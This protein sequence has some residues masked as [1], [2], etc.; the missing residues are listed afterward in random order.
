MTHRE[1][2]VAALT[3]AGLTVSSWAQ[4]TFGDLDEPT[5]LVRY[6]GRATTAGGLTRPVCIVTIVLAVGRAAQH[7]DGQG[8]EVAELEVINACDDHPDLFPSLLATQVVYA[9][10]LTAMLSGQQQKRAAYIA[11]AVTVLGSPI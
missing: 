5:H 3:L 10:N 4:P 11:S 8:L 7:I 9:D 2:V 6:H 1:N